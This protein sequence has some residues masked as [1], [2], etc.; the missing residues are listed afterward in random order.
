MRLYCIDISWHRYSK[1]STS[2]DTGIN[3]VISSWRR[4]FPTRLLLPIQHSHQTHT[5]YHSQNVPSPYSLLS[6]RYLN[7]QIQARQRHRMYLIV[8]HMKP[9]PPPANPLPPPP[10]RFSPYVPLDT[11]PARIPPLCT[12]FAEITTPHSVLTACGLNYPGVHKLT[13]PV[14]A[15]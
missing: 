7:S 10:Q 11:P 6:W 14:C 9:I 1:I 4:S 13:S 5:V 8:A 15:A 12:S 2:T 3:G